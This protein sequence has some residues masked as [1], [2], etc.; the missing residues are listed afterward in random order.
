MHLG[1]DLRILDRPGAEQTGLGRYALEIARALHAAR[2]QWRISAFSNRDDLLS[3]DDRLQ[4]RHTHW[5]TSSSAG[6]I[7]WVHAGSTVTAGGRRPDVWFGPTY[8]IPAWWRGPS[9]V[10]IQDLVFLLLR[11][12]YR[13]KLN[14]LHATWAT[15]LAARRSQRVLCPSTQT[16]DAVN[17]H[18]GVAPAKLRIVPNGVADV[19]YGSPS[20][21][22]PG[23]DPYLLFVGTFEA[24]KG[25][26]TLAAAFGQLEPALRHGVRLVLAG[27]PGWGAE[28]QLAELRALGDVEIVESP[29]D[30]RLAE[31]YR[32]ATALVFPSRMEGFG[33][34]VAEAMAAGA[35]V[36][37]TDLGCVREFAG[38]VPLYSPPS[39][40]PAL[41][42]QIET[43]LGSERLR[44]AKRAAG[45]ATAAALRW[46]A[47][48]ERTAVAIEEAA[49][50]GPTQR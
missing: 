15:R 11:S 23:A 16:A 32:G 27:R 38:D 8:L 37:A 22:E 42:R 20:E 25:L 36:V 2:P 45:R 33:L 19:F 48:G 21:H 4:L 28:Q 35:P 46:S 10:M 39:D 30:E 24:R 1:L 13:G 43:L 18:M 40:A 12:Q 3:S 14:S 50:T 29:S 9:V 6:R 7:L 17:A 44:S 49:V 31:L 34:P 26:D 5:P 41:A 47:V